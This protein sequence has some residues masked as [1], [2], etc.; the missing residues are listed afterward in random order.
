MLCSRCDR[1]ASR[2][3]CSTC[4]ETKLSSLSSR[5]SGTNEVKACSYN[6]LAEQIERVTHNQREIQ[7]RRMIIAA[8]R[9]RTAELTARSTALRTTL[10]RKREAL[11]QVVQAN[12][13]DVVTRPCPPPPSMSPTPVLLLKT[14]HLL[15]G[16]TLSS[17]FSVLG[18]SA[19][20]AHE[21]THRS[22]AADIT[23]TPGERDLYTQSGHSDR[24]MGSA[25]AILNTVLGVVYLTTPG[26]GVDVRVTALPR[27]QESRL[28]ATQQY[29]AI[30]HRARGALGTSTGSPVEEL[31][32]LA[33]PLSEPGATPAPGPTPTLR[34]VEAV[35]GRPHGGPDRARV[36]YDAPSLFDVSSTSLMDALIEDWFVDPEPDVLSR[37]MSGVLP[38]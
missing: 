38:G 26:V 24:V 6:A 36:I 19:W 16:R 11:D 33:A 18:V 30:L 27:D 21:L 1:V 15:R 37:D 34:L 13:D 14:V 2:S 20:A 5:L 9:R 10:Y 4:V 17:A 7:D 29:A 32:R 12:T 22:P 25:L 8:Y 28:A 23:L 31:F 35:M 3:I